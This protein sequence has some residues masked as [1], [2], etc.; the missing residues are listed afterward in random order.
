MG[1]LPVFNERKIPILVQKKELQT[2]L[3]MVWQ[4]KGG[5]Y[6]M[7]DWHLFKVQIGSPLMTVVSNSW[8]ESNSDVQEV[9]R[10][11]TSIARLVKNM[12]IISR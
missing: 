7:T 2:S 6:D 3:Y 11:D 9:T 10:P 12:G 5:A 1:Q 4:G 8:M